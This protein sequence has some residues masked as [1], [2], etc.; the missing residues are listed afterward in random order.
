[1]TIEIDAIRESDFADT[2]I[3]KKNGLDWYQCPIDRKVLL[4]LMEKNDW[5]PFI[6]NIS[7]LIFSLITGLFA[8]WA[9]HN[10]SWPWIVAAVYF[11][12]S[13]Y[14]FFGSGTGGHEL[15]HKTM[16]KTPELNEIFIRINGFLS[17]FNYIYFRCSHVKHHQFTAHDD[18][19]ME[20]ILPQKLKW[21][22]WVF[23]FT[24]NFQAAYVTLKRQIRNAFGY[25]RE[26]ILIT[27][28]EQRIFPETK[29]DTFKRMVN[30]SRIM[31]IGHTVLAILFIVSGNWILLLLVTFPL[32]IAR[33]FV[34][35]THMPQHIGMKPDVA[36]WRHNTRTYLAG[37]IVCF[38]YWN[39]NY[40][41]EHHMYPAVP[42]YNLP[43][44]RKAIESDMPI[45]TRGLVS[46]W[47]QI[48]KILKRQK[49][50]PNYYSELLFPNR[51]MDSIQ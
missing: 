35:L 6:D 34:F 21:Y 13:F 25:R 43:K 17:W 18:L 30:F 45:A 41:V 24:I 44:L 2:K 15:S 28:W 1:M 27:V 7:Q 14:G 5:R 37:P 48:F 9:F 11:H 36:D 40:H 51:S 47:R 39:M 3:G 12:C 46:T 16:F 19:D 38:F 31:V 29:P 22:H 49:Q 42:Y 33:W 50:D 23:A 10:L 4:Q 32:F 8:L 20:V 26:L